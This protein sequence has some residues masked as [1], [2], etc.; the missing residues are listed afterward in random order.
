MWKPSAP[1]LLQTV[2]GCQLDYLG[3]TVTASFVPVLVHDVETQH[4]MQVPKVREIAYLQTNQLHEISKRIF[5]A[6]VPIS[7]DWPQ[8]L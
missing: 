8:T 4:N 7:I 3:T 6:T 1:R 5:M 2:K